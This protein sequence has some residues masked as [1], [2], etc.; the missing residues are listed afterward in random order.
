MRTYGCLYRLDHAFALDNA[1]TGGVTGPV[2]FADPYVASET[3]G[4][5]GPA[6]MFPTPFWDVGSWDLRDGQPCTSTGSASVPGSS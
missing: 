3:Q 2:R 5:F 1:A 6:N 4:A